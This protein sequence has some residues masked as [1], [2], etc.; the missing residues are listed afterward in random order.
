MPIESVRVQGLSELRAALRAVDVKL[1]TELTKASKRAADLVAQRTKESFSA[2]SGVAPKVAASVRSYGQQQ[3]AA[4]GI[5]GP[6]WPFALGSEF[7]SIRY[8]QFP[9]WRGSGGDA[10]YSL[11]PSI[12]SSRDEIVN[13]Y[14]DMIEAL[15]SAH[16]AGT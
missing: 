14:G 11:Y 12:R 15:L 16:A 3:K 4:V 8:K 7:G 1:P 9:A 2:R 6:Q 5:G 13:L 10:G